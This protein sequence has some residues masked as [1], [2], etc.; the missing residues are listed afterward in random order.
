MSFI[1]VTVAPGCAADPAKVATWCKA[2]DLQARE[3]AACWGVACTPVLFFSADVLDKLDGEEL[4]TFVSRAHLLTIQDDLDVPG[5][6]GF[7]ADIAGVIF[8]RVLFQGD[9]TSVTL[10]HEV[11]EEIGDPTCEDFAD[12]GGGTFQAREACDRVEGDAYEVTVDDETVRLSNYLLPAAFAI[13]SARPWDRLDR[14]DS[15]S[16]M[17]PGGYVIVRDETGRVD[18]VFASTAAAPVFAAKRRNASSRVARR[19]G[20]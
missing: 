7:H 20:P 18:S 1:A 12:M 17:T 14:L 6:L 4:T 19:C 16:G 5:A 9:A 13:D 8:S 10:S 2:V 15:W 3:F 11:L